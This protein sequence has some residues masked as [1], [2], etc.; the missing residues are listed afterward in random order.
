[1]D[2]LPQQHAA[3]GVLL[4]DGLERNESISK[5]LFRTDV[6]DNCSGSDTTS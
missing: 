2:L 1:M 5:D 6:I 3:H 4:G